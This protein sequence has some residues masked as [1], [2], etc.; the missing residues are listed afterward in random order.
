MYSNCTANNSYAISRDGYA[1]IGITPLTNIHGLNILRGI[2]IYFRAHFSQDFCVLQ[3]MMNRNDDI[4]L[5]IIFNCINWIVVIPIFI[6]YSMYFN[7]FRSLLRIFLTRWKGLKGLIDLWNNFSNKFSCL[8][9]SDESDLF[10]GMCI[11]KM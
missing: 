11:C 7:K 4:P 2:S 8:R 1:S 10:E 6:N 3:I 9:N 5:F